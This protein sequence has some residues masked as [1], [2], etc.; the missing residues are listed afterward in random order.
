MPSLIDTP[1]YRVDMSNLLHTLASIHFFTVFIS[2]SGLVK[3]LSDLLTA[4][5]TYS[6]IHSFAYLLTS[7]LIYSFNRLLV[8]VV[9]CSFTY[10]PTH[11]PISSFT[12][13]FTHLLNH[14]SIHSL[15]YS[16]THLIIYSL[17]P[18]FTYNSSQFTGLFSADFLITF[19][20]K[21][22][23]VWT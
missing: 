1:Q 12:P 14:S 4:E 8:H 16:L 18:A 11:S 6:V 19:A 13:W 5:L 17:I 20:C 3:Q 23:S 22:F 10:S 21:P 2:C 9:T 7:S 15:I